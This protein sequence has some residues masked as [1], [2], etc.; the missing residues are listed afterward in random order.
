MRCGSKPQRSG[1]TPQACSPE[2]QAT[3]VE[4]HATSSEPH[5]TGVGP[6]ATSS[7]PHA[8]GFGPQASGL[9][10]QSTGSD[11]F[12][13][14]AAGRAWSRHPRGLARSA[15]P[16]ADAPRRPVRSAL[17]GLLR[18]RE[19]LFLEVRQHLALV[20][21]VEEPE[22]HDGFGHGV[23]LGVEVGQR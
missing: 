11:A 18:R 7:E 1:F 8:S 9:E 19:H 21:L 10:P 6:Q 14:S 23:R 22:G 12:R 15:L 13:S 2:P 4:P 5:A 17:C 3:G 20:G 16:C